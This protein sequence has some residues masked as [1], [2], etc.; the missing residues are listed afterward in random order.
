MF[1]SAARCFAYKNAVKETAVF[2]FFMLQMQYISVYK[3]VTIKTI[4]G[5]IKIAFPTKDKILNSLR[6]KAQKKVRRYCHD[7]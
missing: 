6:K 5:R 2:F 4:K 3:G 1:H 7:D